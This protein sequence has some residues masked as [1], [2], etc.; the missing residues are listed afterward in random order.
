MPDTMQVV[1]ASGGARV[2]ISDILAQPTFVRA[3]LLDI[4]DYMF[5]GDQLFRDAGS[6]PSGA[7]IYRASTPLF[8]DTFENSDYQE[9]EE[10][11]TA[12]TALGIPKTS[13]AQERIL[14]V[15]VSDR[16]KRRNDVDALNV[17]LTQV[18]NTLTQIFDGKAM[19]A[20]D[21]N[22]DAS[23]IFNAATHWDTSTTIRTDLAAAGKG[24][25]GKKLGFNPDTILMSQSLHWELLGNP[26]VWKV[27]QG[28]IAGD[29]PAVTGVMPQK[30]WN[31]NVVVTLD[32]NLVDP[33]AAYVMQRGIFGGKC[34]EY[35]LSSTPWYR[36][37]ERKCQRSDVGRSTAYFIDQPLAIAKIEGAAA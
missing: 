13:Q 21:A 28:N 23:L 24:I 1:S 2:A 35:P 33:T 17:Q 22:V 20:I 12:I 30:L 15:E 16:M 18:Q 34:D 10:V 7:V 26:D 5:T 27:Y 9:F 32:Q 8:A 6:C 37:E 3:Y 31:M 36:Q 14:G 4:S 11:P 19:A 29:S 25:T